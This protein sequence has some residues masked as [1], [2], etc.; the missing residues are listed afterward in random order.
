MLILSFNT[1]AKSIKNKTY[2]N[3]I[4]S[5]IVSIYDGDTFK[6]NIKDIH[7]L[8]G[9][10][11]GIR[12]VGIDTPE[13]RS[14]CKSE[15]ALARKAKQFTVNFLRS[16]EVIELRNVKRDK[17]FRIDAEVYGDG[18]SLY[19]LLLSNGLGVKYT[20]GKKKDWCENEIN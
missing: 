9:E 17:Y 16:A 3:L 19:D 18:V 11:I 20:G 2:G 15:K 7:P 6:A 5:E 13:I 8:I 14:K 1:N 12:L 10:R 4:V